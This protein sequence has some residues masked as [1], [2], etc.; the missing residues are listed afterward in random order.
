MSI[1]FGGIDPLKLIEGILNKM[2]LKGLIT[3][4]EAQGIIDSAK[5]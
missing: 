3:K 1:T 4:D 2:I 5:S